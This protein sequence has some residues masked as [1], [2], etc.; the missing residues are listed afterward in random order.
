MMYLRELFILPGFIAMLF[1]PAGT[2]GAADWPMWRNDV[3]RS[4]ST[5]EELP[6]ELH[7][8]WTRQLPAPVPAWPNESRLQFDASYEP[9]VLGSHM[10]VG[11]MNDGSVRALDCKT[12]RERWCFYTNGPVRLAP[13][14]SG[15]SVYFGSDDGWLYCVNAETG[16][17]SWKVPGA[18]QHRRSHRHLGNAQL[19]SFWPVRGGPVIADG[20]V[21]F[22]AGIWPTLGV[23]VHAVDARTGEILWTNDSS[24]A[25]AD[26][27]VDHN[28]Q[29]ESGISPQG[30][31]LVR[32]D[33]LIV[34][35]GRSMPARF[36]RKTGRLHYFVQGYRNGD[37]RV[38]VSGDIA[39]VGLTGVVNLKDG[40]EIANRWVAAGKDA[41][42]GW[43]SAKVDLF[44]GP[45]FPYRFQ[46]GCDYR[47]VIHSGTAY[48]V[49]N[50]T[51]RAFD[52]TKAETSMDSRTFNGKPI[53]PGRWD[54]P[55]IWNL[56][57]QFTGKQLQTRSLIKAGNRLYAHSG[58]NLF[59]VELNPDAG[60]PGTVAWT[61]E[62]SSPPT[63]L[64]AASGR[65]FIVTADGMIH[66][67]G[68]HPVESSGQVAAPPGKPLRSPPRT[69]LVDSV[70]Q[71]I[72]DRS[73]YAVV[74]G[75]TSG[76]VVED[77]LN[78]SRFHVIAV[79]ADQDRVDQLRRSIG[80][81]AQF[82]S[83][84]QAIVAPPSAAGL[85]PYLASLI[86]SEA[87]EELPLD[88]VSDLQ[89]LYS[90]LRPYG[91]TLCLN[92]QPP[93]LE[94]LM[95]DFS[96]D[97]FPGVEVSHSNG[98]LVVRRTGALP[99]SSIWSHESG[100]AARSFY[101]RDELVRAPLAVLWYGDGRDHGFHKRKDYGHGLKPQVAGGRLFALQV[102]TN[103]LKAVDA[104]TGRLL[105]SRKL[106]A[107][108]RYASMPDSVYVAD[109]RTCLVLDPAN[110]EIRSTYPVHVDQ[111]ADVPVS[112]TAIR[113][114]E[115]TILIAVRFNRE[116]AISKGRWDSSLIVVLDRATGRQLW[117]RPAALR[118]HMAAIAVS[119]GRVFCIDSHSPAQIGLMRRRGENV[120]RLPST[121][122]ALEASTGRE[123]WRSVQTE[124]PAVLT[125]LH[126]MSLRTQDDWLACSSDQKLVIAGKAGQTF[127]LQT[128]TGEIVWR[129]A[130]RGEQPL[131]LGSGKFINQA[132]RTYDVRTGS[133][134]SGAALFRRGGCNYAVG[135]RN[136]LFLR[137]N[138]ATYVDINSR[139]EYAIRNLRSGCSNSLV[140]A[141]GLLNAPCFSV[142]CVCNYPI[143]TSF[144][145]FHMPESADW[146]GA[147][148]IR[149][150]QP[151]NEPV[152]GAGKTPAP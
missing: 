104:Y 94:A 142:G 61:K 102:A 37:S 105:W 60:K 59:A 90:S 70:F 43:S 34:P 24:H 118:Y 35:N 79:A 135:G 17:L 96:P 36:D 121:I 113:V 115:N 149:Q 140:A 41:P 106:G 45:L 101:S 9:I 114:G 64:L 51:V 32:G 144:A 123:L 68:K 44:E 28:Y 47:S 13:V 131:I 107:S 99:G 98:L 85:P 49:E 139:Q 29:Q 58:Q 71:A 133:L 12:G 63:S 21:Y 8:Q 93:R 62:L 129:K 50:G 124:P 100:D 75:L 137:S 91:G 74:A 88:S 67:M 143:Q 147:S 30:H 56:E 127:A 23:F 2:V 97:R 53:R 4:G 128:E 150:S 95:K 69:A 126:F 25:I 81:A 117:S 26:V 82:R 16:E 152:T 19:V 130:M 146:H 77:L 33:M 112:P 111:P 20:V 5:S 14:A 83:R 1:M 52:L 116:N 54:A 39:L 3:L 7:L 22:G 151:E 108:A 120:D 136:L 89:S 72:T 138:C 145:M 122:L 76:Q 46:P 73:G 125:T 10:Y 38:I 6:A 109:G 42:Q 92:L 40:R 119:G 110:G 80:A 103:T 15:D 148:P 27:R 48:G 11:S 141:D 57:T 134:L 31:L 65:L 84:F 18:P 87:P 78:R 66:C 132:G 86:I 55:E